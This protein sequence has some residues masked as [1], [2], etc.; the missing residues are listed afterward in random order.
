MQT[1]RSKD[2]IYDGIDFG[3]NREDPFICGSYIHF[4]R[5]H[6]QEIGKTTNIWTVYEGVTYRG[7]ALGQVRWFARW[8]KYSFYPEASTVFEQTCLREIAYF[9]ESATTHHKN[10]KKAKSASA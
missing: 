1:K 8:R 3:L 4:R 9:C 6:A 7:I 5:E 2:A 10:Q